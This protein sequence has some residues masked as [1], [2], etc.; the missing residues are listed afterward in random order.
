MIASLCLFLSACPESYRVIDEE[1]R[2][3]DAGIR[4]K[5][6]RRES[7]QTDGRKQWFVEADE[8]FIYQK[9]KQPE[10]IVAYNFRFEQYDA[11]GNLTDLMT[12]DRGEID[13]D[14][15]MFYLSGNVYFKGQDKGRTV[16]AEE[17]EYDRI[18]EILTSDKPI[19]IIEEGLTTRCT[20]G[21]EVDYANNRQVCKGPV[22]ISVSNSSSEQSAGD[23]FQ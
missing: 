9:G 19:T 4:I 6:F 20:R 3:N 1:V 17:V 14:D 22:V 10:R 18:E 8:A 21:A 16:R 2:E 15:E 5:D 23:L 13:Q 12:A 11:D 7:V